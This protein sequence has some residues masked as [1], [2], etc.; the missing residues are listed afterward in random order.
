V[1][2][3]AP[4]TPEAILKALGPVDAVAALAPLV[5]SPARTI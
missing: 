1:E 5:T 3:D 4:A 2:L